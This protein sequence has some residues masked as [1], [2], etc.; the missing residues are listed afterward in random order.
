MGL[1]YRREPASLQ[2][3]HFN[4]VRSDGG[5]LFDDIIRADD[6]DLRR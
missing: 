5:D 2:W 3:S 6:F 1:R 4:V